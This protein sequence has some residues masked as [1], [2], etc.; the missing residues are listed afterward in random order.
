MCEKKSITCC[1]YIFVS[2]LYK[3]TLHASL[4]NTHIICIYKQKNNQSLTLV[5]T[6]SVTKEEKIETEYVTRN[7]TRYI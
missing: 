1:I 2:C 3:P 4:I 6:A 7:F 5:P